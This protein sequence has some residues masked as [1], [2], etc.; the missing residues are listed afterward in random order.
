MI[1]HILNRP[2]T[3]TLTLLTPFPSHTHTLWAKTILATLSFC[4]PPPLSELGKRANLEDNKLICWAM[5]YAG[6]YSES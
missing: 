3:F 4:R 1:R 2:Q 5:Q 6:S